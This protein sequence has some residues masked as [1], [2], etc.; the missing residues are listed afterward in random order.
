MGVSSAP[1]KWNIPPVSEWLR[2]LERP[3]E[4]RLEVK[5]WAS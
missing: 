1:G 3:V 5:D 2:A 4:P